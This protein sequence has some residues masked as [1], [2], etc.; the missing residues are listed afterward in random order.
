MLLVSCWRKS[1]D[2][3]AQPLLESIES[4]VARGD[5]ESAIDSIVVLRL[6]YP[7]A[8]RARQRALYL[9]QE[10]KILRAEH[11]AAVIDSMLQATLCAIDTAETLLEANL[12]RDRRDSLRARYDANIGIIKVIREKQKQQQEHTEELDDE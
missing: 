10:A 7:K 1:A 2:E 6:R 8:I 3:K 12:L 4:S 9:D 11:E 5:Y